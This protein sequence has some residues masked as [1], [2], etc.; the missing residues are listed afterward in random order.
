MNTNTA[1]NARIHPAINMYLNTMLK[2]F[3]PIK[4]IEANIKPP[5]IKSSE[6]GN[7]TPNRN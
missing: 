6:L 3:I 7:V 2:N 5:K 4:N 1:I